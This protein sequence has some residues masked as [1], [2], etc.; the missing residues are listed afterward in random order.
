MLSRRIAAARPLF[1]SSVTVTAR[2]P[3]SQI[4]CVS[5]ADIDD[6]E[7]VSE[8]YLRYFAYIDG[9]ELINDR[10]VAILTLLVSN[11]NSA[12][13]MATGG[14]NKSVATLASQYTKIMM[15]WACSRLKN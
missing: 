8:L 12:I 10:M 6:P 15:F 5:Q 1:R 7:M 3:L 14:T 13:L 4:R 11:V 2:T 9:L